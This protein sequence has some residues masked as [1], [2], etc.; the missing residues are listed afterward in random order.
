MEVA[1]QEDRAVVTNNLRHFRPIAAQR[2][3]QGKQHA[4]LVLLP[5]NRARNRA[6]TGRLADAIEAVMRAHP[7]RDSR[8]RA[9]DLTAALTPTPPIRYKQRYA[10][11]RGIRPHKPTGGANAMPTYIMLSTLT[12]EGVQTVK[13]NPQ[14]IQ[15]VNKEVEQLGATVK[16]QWATLGHVDFIIGRSR[17]PT[18]GRWRASRS[19]WARAGTGRYET[20]SAIPVDEFIASSLRAC[21]ASSSVGCAAAR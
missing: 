11:K 13:N 14:R 1:T 2:R 8:R 19:S 18:R 17:R 7:E 12:P 10:R 9:L 6:A 21:Q 20:L 5:S 3:A 15:E 16:A 4:G